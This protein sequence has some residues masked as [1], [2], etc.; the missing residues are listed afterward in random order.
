MNISFTERELVHILS[1][2]AAHDALV[3]MK[4]DSIVTQIAWAMRE[5]RKY[6]WGEGG[7]PPS[8]KDKL[9]EL[10]F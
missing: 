8:T 7:D 4:C 2:A 6:S 9:E 5:V 1:L 3:C 10:P